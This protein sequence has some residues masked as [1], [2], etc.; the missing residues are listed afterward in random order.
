[1]VKSSSVGSEARPAVKKGQVSHHKSPSMASTV[2]EQLRASA[3]RCSA[4]HNSHSSPGAR[5]YGINTPV[6]EPMS[7]ASIE[8]TPEDRSRTHNS[9]RD[10]YQ[11]PSDSEIDNPPLWSSASKSSSFRGN[12]ENQHKQTPSLRRSSIRPP[13]R[14]LLIVQEANNQV[15]ETYTPS[16]AG[17]DPAS[18]RYS[19][20]PRTSP[21]APADA[22]VISLMTSSS[23]DTPS[24]LTSTRT[25]TARPGVANK[26]P[27][28]AVV[29]SLLDSSNS[30]ASSP[31]TH[32]H[33]HVQIPVDAEVISLDTNSSHSNEDVANSSKSV[34]PKSANTTKTSRRPPRQYSAKSTS[35]KGK[36][37]QTKTC[38]PSDLE[39]ERKPWWNPWDWA[40]RYGG[41]EFEIKGPTVWFS[42]GPFKG[43][44]INGPHEGGYM[45]GY[46]APSDAVLAEA[47]KNAVPKEKMPE[48]WE[49]SSQ[50]SD[51]A[52][53]I[54]RSGF[55]VKAEV[56]TGDLSLEMP[57]RVP[58]TPITAHDD[59]WNNSEGSIG[60]Q[61]PQVGR[62][63]RMEKIQLLKLNNASPTLPGNLAPASTP[64]RDSPFLSTNSESTSVL[65]TRQ[66]TI[67]SSPPPSNQELAVLVG[68]SPAPRALEVPDSQEPSDEYCKQPQSSDELCHSDSTESEPKRIRASIYD[69]PPSSQGGIL[70]NEIPG[71]RMI[72][73]GAQPLPFTTS[74]GHMPDTET[75]NSKSKC[76]ELPLTPSPAQ[77]NVHKPKEA[78][79]LSSTANKEDIV[80]ELPSM[81]PAQQSQY[82]PLSY[83]SSLDPL[84]I[85][86]SFDELNDI[87]GGTSRSTQ[88]SDSN[89]EA[90]VYTLR[91]SPSWL[92][93]ITEV[94]ARA[95]PN[96]L[97]PRP[98]CRSSRPFGSQTRASNGSNKRVLFGQENSS[99][100]A[101]DKGKNRDSECATH[102]TYTNE[103][104][105]GVP[106]PYTNRI[107]TSK[108]LGVKK[109]HDFIT[110]K[111]DII[112]EPDNPRQDRHMRSITSKPSKSPDYTVPTSP[113]VLRQQSFP[114]K[115]SSSL[116]N[117]EPV[118]T[119]NK[120]SPMLKRETDEKV[121]DHETSSMQL[122]KITP[123]KKRKASHH[124]H[125]DDDGATLPKK[126]R[127]TNTDRERNSIFLPLLPLLP[128]NKLEPKSSLKL[129]L[130][131][132]LES[133]P[134]SENGNTT[135]E[136]RRR[137][138]IEVKR[139][140][141]EKSPLLRSPGP[142]IIN[143]RK[144]D[145]KKKRHRYRI[146]DGE[147]PSPVSASTS[148][149]FTS[150]NGSRG[151]NVC[152]LRE[153]NMDKTGL[154]K[155]RMGKEEKVL[156]MKM[157]M[158]MNNNNNTNPNKNERNRKTEKQEKGEMMEVTSSNNTSRTSGTIMTPPF[159]S[160]PGS[161]E[162]R[163]GI[164]L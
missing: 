124:H 142:Y 99:E 157:N 58:I 11:I 125:E 90:L 136:K 120:S 134:A 6:R 122:S 53:D 51:D 12:R 43:Y 61:T 54:E 116:I 84:Y 126:R 137:R 52:E 64:K 69:V 112:Q 89:E 154:K 47:E 33:A 101:Q 145:G 91:E 107:S 118:H 23:D 74:M 62:K 81:T 114:T 143:S 138:R 63:V 26:C 32:R 7:L 15:P 117:P 56:V 121:T 19:Q 76:K 94:S 65:I 156:G 10:P 93:S 9:I 113:S 162:P 30:R 83:T 42:D 80:V 105:L 130:E 140:N 104:G 159:T 34:V 96:S 115:R 70:E 78:I 110:K 3:A 97:M 57:N 139:H 68:S 129:E 141:V 66:L 119:H 50:S 148:T 77:E 109:Q 95:L 37:K 40:R 75:C 88:N 146:M 28:D 31:K 127:N 86:K 1:M 133:A 27:N 14:S 79:A 132:D 55:M 131:S 5:K 13:P 82:A 106:L 123:T 39:V 59:H 135:P 71:N 20:Q 102:L 45:P 161:A 38:E 21:K 128:L 100:E 149:S 35:T 163:Y 160:R 144:R 108:P 111:E 164:G 44:I 41:T 87:T 8:R 155:E 25:S 4:T 48:I 98:R 151:G 67:Q 46:E 73:S 92:S 22:Q 49:I 24:P 72:R 152:K 60:D 147:M 36:Q 16:R 29:V 85:P 17:P 153:A 2:L 103:V 158:A 150:C 18:F